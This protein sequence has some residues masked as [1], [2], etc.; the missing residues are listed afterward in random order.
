MKKIDISKID[1]NFVRQ[2]ADGIELKFI[3]A[4]DDSLE[5]CG[6]PWFPKE[7]EYCRLPQ[8]ILDKVSEGVSVLSWQTSGGSIRFRTNST[9]IALEVKLDGLS[10]M[11]HMPRTGSSGF[12]LFTGCGKT[13]VFTGNLRPDADEVN[14]S[15]I[16]SKELSNKMQDY[17]IY[18]PL[19][20]G[21]KE[22]KIGISP[23][24]EI[25]APS[26]FAIEKP[27]MFYGSSITQG[28]CASRPANSYTHIAARRLNANFINWGFSGNA[29][30]EPIMAETIA[31]LEMSV[32][33]I[34]YDANAPS[35]EHLIDTH[36]AFFKI[37]RD[38]HPELPIIIISK[39]HFYGTELD[40]KRREIICATYKNA[41]K[42]G[43]KNCY[44]I[45]GET[46]FGNNER[47]LCTVDRCHPNDIGFLRMA[48]TV[49][50]VLQQA[51]S[52][53]L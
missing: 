33:V 17:T 30:G 8:R 44:F 3:D 15:G 4:K 48:D 5:Q 45:D 14:F 42:N 36:E 53:K 22:V 39:P 43:D 32:L 23:E 21:V 1:K 9:V 25:A 35:P 34:D 7:R 31:E 28:G 27:I 19:Y 38:K 11:S 29:K 2:T 20:N 24:A 41:L 46:L 47:D 37:I 16:F 49:T 12:D 26:P 13:S 52:K 51:L 40:C 50:P 6:F 10:N 18:F